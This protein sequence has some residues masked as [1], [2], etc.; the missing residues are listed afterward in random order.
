MRH[1]NPTV[2]LALALVM[3]SLVSS[4]TEEFAFRGYA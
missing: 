4:L 2:T 1:N 3:G